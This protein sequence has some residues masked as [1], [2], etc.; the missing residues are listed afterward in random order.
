MS[1]TAVPGSPTKVASLNRGREGGRGG[2]RH[3]EDGDEDQENGG[4]GRHFGCCCEVT[5]YICLRKSRQ[6][7]R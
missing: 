6:V 3:T 4:A 1:V 2:S 5:R 7:R